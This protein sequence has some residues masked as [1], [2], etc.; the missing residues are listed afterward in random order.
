MDKQD[1]I[2]GMV[3]RDQ[4]TGYEGI[5]TSQ[6]R[7]LHGCDRVSVQAPVTDGRVPDAIHVDIL[8]VLVLHERS[9]YR[10]PNIPPAAAGG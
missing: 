3:V 9:P 4:V 1:N 10:P 5:V 8:S 6:T 7:Y 2:V